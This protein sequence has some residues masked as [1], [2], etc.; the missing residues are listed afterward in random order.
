M[1]F[2]MKTRII[3]TDIYKDETM[4]SLTPDAR[5]IVVYLYTNSHIGLLDLY[6]IPV[7]LIQLETGY[8]I[9]TIKLV[10]DKSQEL[11]IIQHHKHLWV[12]L[13]RK[14]FGALVYSGESN[15]IAIQ[16][17]LSEIPPEVSIFF[18]LDGSVDTSVQSTYK[19]EIR[20][21]KSKIRN[22]KESEEKKYGHFNNVL[23]SEKEHTD[24]VEQLNENAV[25]TLIGELDGYI[26]STGKKYRSHYA[27]IQNWAR[28]R[29][30]EHS[31]K[32]RV[33]TKLKR[34]II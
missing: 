21:K 1:G 22:Q 30:R 17:Y 13:L 6:K 19:S 20:N 14:D 18:G 5:F 16:K 32:M 7:Q 25:I 12:K 29:I 33:G 28:R 26:E 10:L 34:E 2:F 4:L 8:D 24:L 9:S 3:R 23:L 31:D 11:K 27:T 15:E